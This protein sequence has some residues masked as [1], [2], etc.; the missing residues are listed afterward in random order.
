M[1]ISAV[2]QETSK[3]LSKYNHIFKP[4]NEIISF[5]DSRSDF[6]TSINVKREVDRIYREGNSLFMSKS[7]LYTS[8]IENILGMINPKTCIE[9]CITYS[10]KIDDPTLFNKISF[11]YDDKLP[12]IRSKTR[13]KIANILPIDV[14]GKENA[15]K[16]L[17]KI[18]LTENI[19]DQ[20][21]SSID[22]LFDTLNIFEAS[23]ATFRK[24]LKNIAN[25]N[26]R[27]GSENRILI[28]K[29]ND[30]LQKDGM[31]LVLD[32]SKNYPFFKI[33]EQE[34]KPNKAPDY[35]IFGAIGTK[36][37]IGISDALDGTVSVISDDGDPLTYDRKI[38]DH[39]NWSDMEDWWDEINIY[40]NLKLRTRLNNCLDSKA[41]EIFFKSYFSLFQEK[42]GEKLPALIPQ[43]YIAYDPMRAKDLEGGKTRIRQRI[44]FLMILPNLKRVIIE[45]DGKHHYAREDGR[46]D[47]KRYAEM[48]KVDR[49][50][51][52]RGYEVYRFGGAEFYND[53]NTPEDNAVSVVKDFFT[54]LFKQ[55]EIL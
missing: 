5:L 46:A 45:I 10:N 19:K 49:D 16:E 14:F 26:L 42:L 6:L 24:L 22:E 32:E 27:D 47:T 54:A 28:A 41:E 53:Q 44:D 55:H 13:K 36:P 23:T 2:I 3:Y 12:P 21:F 40:P 33:K 39:L 7:W 51:R 37:N 34:Y 15:S 4:E 1:N 20:R 9:F 25:S 18:F 52:L 11:Y 48:V 35:L 17:S 30:V 29:I 8:D 43:V 38:I 31:I 50:L